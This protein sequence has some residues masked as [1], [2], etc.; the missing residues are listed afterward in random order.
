L[1]EVRQRGLLIG[2]QMANENCGPLLTRAL[3]QN[4]VL[5]IFAGLD[6]TVTIIMPPLIVTKE[7]V[8]LILE[9]LDLSYQI[10]AEQMQMLA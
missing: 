7:E 10:M 9:A 5:A 8:D 1:I 6:P 2:L 3:G 4:G